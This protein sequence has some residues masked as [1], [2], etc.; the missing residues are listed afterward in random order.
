[1]PGRGAAL[2]R[3]TIPREGSPVLVV[4]WVAFCKAESGFR[5][6]GRNGVRCN[7]ASGC[8]LGELAAAGQAVTAAVPEPC[9]ARC[10]LFLK[11]I[12]RCREK[13]GTWLDL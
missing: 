10:W 1:M 6:L 11:G 2:G 4:P 13:A 3:W 12:S 9:P 5:A 7:L 8:L